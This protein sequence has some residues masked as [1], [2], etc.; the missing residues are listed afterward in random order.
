MIQSMTGYGEASLHNIKCEIK[1][2]NH[3]FLSTTLSLPPSLSKYE[4]KIRELIGAYLKRG[5]IFLKLFVESHQV[6]PDLEQAK[7]YYNFVE[8]LKNGLELKGEIPL[9]LFLDFRKEKVLTWDEIK[10]IVVLSLHKVIKSRVEEGKKIKQDMEL[11]LKRL[12]SLINQ[13]IKKTPNQKKMEQEF[14][15]KLN[16]LT[17]DKLDEQKVREELTILLLRENFNE[18]I[19]RLDAHFNKFRKV[20]R[21]KEPSG[22]ELTFLLQ[23]MQREANTVSAK[24]K[25]AEISQLTV[26]IKTDIEI[27]MEQAENVR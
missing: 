22:K 12:K 21:R 8:K 27:L 20:V 18:E 5:A 26:E 6:E 11:H 15:T 3:R 14:K 2:L 24:A 19:V 25:N 1:A 16:S 13:I 23:E 4:F 7:V 9:S 10:P 17:R